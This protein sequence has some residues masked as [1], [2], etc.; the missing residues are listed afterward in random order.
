MLLIYW[1][2]QLVPGVAISFEL[3]TEFN[4]RNIK[5]NIDSDQQASLSSLEV[6]VSRPRWREKVLTIWSNVEDETPEQ[7]AGYVRILILVIFHVSDLVS[8]LSHVVRRAWGGMS[9][10]RSTKLQIYQ[11]RGKL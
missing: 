10:D 3:E 5:E 4:C 2:K 7:I 8:M 6:L 1:P 11:G 9:V